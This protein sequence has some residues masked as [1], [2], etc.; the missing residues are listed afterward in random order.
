MAQDAQEAD[1]LPRLSI[2]VLTMAR[3]PLAII[4]AFLINFMEHTISLLAVCFLLLATIEITDML[5]G[6]LARRWKLVTEWGA[7][8]DPY[9][10]STSRLIVFFALA[11]SGLAL[12]LVPLIMALRDVTVAYSRIT[13][14]RCGLSVAAKLSGKIKAVI[15][16]GA[17]PLLLFGPLY[18]D[19]VGGQWPMA[20]VSWIV[21]V[22]TAASAVQYTK[23]AIKAAM[24]VRPKPPQKQ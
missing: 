6:F 3:I 12:P 13:L 24:E 23:S 4:F 17:G 15:Q 18:W 20:V 21:M 11:F 1:N 2:Q 5:D 16:G 19:H 9:A 7:M 22:V 10:D 8:L 14:T